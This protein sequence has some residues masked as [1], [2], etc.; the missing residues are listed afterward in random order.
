MLGERRRVLLKVAITGPESTGKS[1]LAEKLAFHYHSNWVKEYSREYLYNLGRPY[2]LQDVERIADM[3][4]QRIGE[5][6]QTMNNFLFADTEM[7]VC[8]IWAEYVFG[9]VPKSIVKLLQKQHFD[10]FLLCNID[11]PWVPDPLRE[12]PNE[13]EILFERYESELIQ[14]KLPY[15]IVS[16]LNNERFFSGVKGVEELIK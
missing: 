13:R 9:I 15:R 10:L 4:M 5:A 2:T 12:H 7:L 16:G 3:Q 14:L 6:S 11:L 8:A 1:W